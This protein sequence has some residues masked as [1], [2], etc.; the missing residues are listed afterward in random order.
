MKQNYHFSENKE[1]RLGS[2]MDINS[3]TES[4]Y[5]SDGRFRLSGDKVYFQADGREIPVIINETAKD[6]RYLMYSVCYEG[7]YI[8]GMLSRLV[9]DAYG[10]VPSDSLKNPVLRYKDKNT[11]NCSPENLYWVSHSELI[12]DSW[13][14]RKQKKLLTPCVSCGYVVDEKKVKGLCS[15]CTAKM[16][17]WEKNK[18]NFFFYNDLLV[19]A[20]AAGLS[21]SAIER[22]KLRRSGETL[23]SIAQRFNVTR[24]GIRT[25][26]NRYEK[27]ILQYRRSQKKEIKTQNVKPLDL[28]LK[29]K[30][31][32]PQQ[33]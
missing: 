29:T 31:K 24:E 23:G 8:R 1:E 14:S 11:K 32:E 26:L 30:T 9:A 28:K 2:V 21:E 33:A 5:T 15:S 10:I 17:K 18:E 16:K 4:K 19:D 12:Q 27:K 22:M 20:K 7:K 3:N 13:N 25:S 6:N